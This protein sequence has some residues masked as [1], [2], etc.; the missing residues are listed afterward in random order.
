MNN[1]NHIVVIDP[2]T[3][4]PETDCFN[5]IVAMSPIPC[6]Y[7]LPALFGADSLTFENPEYIKA[8]IV[9]GGSGS[10][11]SKLDWRTKLEHW[12]DKCLQYDIP[13]LGIC[14]GH[15]WIASFMG[16][17]VDLIPGM[18]GNKYR[19]VREI[20]V[21]CNELFPTKKTGQVIVSHGSMVTTA[22]SEI[23]CFVTSDI[24][25][26]EGF[27]YTKKPIYSFQS[28]PEA[29]LAFMKNNAIKTN[30]TEDYTFGHSLVS[31]FINWSLKYNK[32]KL[33]SLQT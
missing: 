32:R 30:G 9:L 7:H 21:H 2:G 28:H 12:F 14:W 6:T 25:I 22:P 19:G 27:K 33:T 10:L 17:E 8:I 31:E 11:T 26:N 20:N 1:F 4:V 5:N 18:N 3:S 24:L 23:E 15:Q 16:G 13:T 29:T